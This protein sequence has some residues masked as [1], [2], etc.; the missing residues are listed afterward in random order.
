MSKNHTTIAKY[1]FNKFGRP[2]VIRIRP[3]HIAKEGREYT[4]SDSICGVLSVSVI[5]SEP[6]EDH[7]ICKICEQMIQS[8]NHE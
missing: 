8:N 6:P 5:I 3:Y 7:R 4:F 2:H 1:V